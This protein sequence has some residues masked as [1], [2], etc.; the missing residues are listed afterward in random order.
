MHFSYQTPSGD[1]SALPF[2]KGNVRTQAFR[3]DQRLAQNG[4]V[5]VEAEHASNTCL[6]FPIEERGIRVRL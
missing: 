1:R 2:P 3:G 5:H 4:V 6:W